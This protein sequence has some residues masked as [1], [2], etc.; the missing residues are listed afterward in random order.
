MAQ[1]KVRISIQ[2]ERGATTEVE[3]DPDTLGA[4]ASATQKE[5]DELSQGSERVEPVFQNIVADLANAGEAFRKAHEQTKK[6]VPP[7]SNP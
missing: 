5:I 3:V 7:S 6:T 1:P 4:L 2:I